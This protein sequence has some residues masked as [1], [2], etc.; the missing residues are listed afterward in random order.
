MRLF[1][2]KLY[3]AA[4]WA[5]ALCLA[6][7]AL[8]VGIQL[9]GRLLDGALMLLHLPPTEFQ[10]LSLAEISGYMLAAA[11][12]MALA[13]TLKGGAHIRVTMALN[14]LPPALRRAAELL[15]FGIACVASAY[16]T[17]Q[18][19]NFAYVSYKFNEVS[20]GVIRVQLAYPQAFV[21]LGTLI[22]TIALIDELVTIV[23]S[24]RPSFRDAEEAFTVGKE[25]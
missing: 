6:T 14:G 12:F 19:A 7:I 16:M 9:G 18:F 8:L 20:A 1:L 5:A 4:L 11:S 21:A 23:M 13:P 25:G 22:L 3:E 10:I 2:D 15:A 17:W 24:D